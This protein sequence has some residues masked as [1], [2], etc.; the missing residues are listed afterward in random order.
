AAGLCVALPV[1]LCASSTFGQVFVGVIR[2]Y[3]PVLPLAVFVAYA[4][5]VADRTRENK[6]QRLLR[7][8]SLGYLMGYLGMAAIGVVLLVLPG[9]HGSKR[10]KTFAST[11]QLH[12]WPSTKL[13]YELSSSRKYVLALLEE[14][15]GT[16]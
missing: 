14:E 4:F 3:I 10:R 16:V 2:Y 1:F 5:G 13:N 15:P 7:M 11:S 9:E 6:M 8:T 12:P